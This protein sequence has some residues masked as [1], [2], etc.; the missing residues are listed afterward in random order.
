L[1]MVT[2]RFFQNGL[3]YPVIQFIYRRDVG[4]QT[5][6]KRQAISESTDEQ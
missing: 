2:L 6:A 3:L 5:V 1:L 4:E